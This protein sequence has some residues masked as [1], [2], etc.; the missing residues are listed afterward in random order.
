MS[1]KEKICSLAKSGI[2]SKDMLGVLL[3][4]LVG[5]EKFIEI[6]GEIEKY[7]Y[8]EEKEYILTGLQISH[9]LDLAYF[10][11]IEKMHAESGKFDLAQRPVE[12][13]LIRA[14]GNEIYTIITDIEKVRE[15]RVANE[16]FK[17]WG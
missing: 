14:A 16:V 4:E 15:D 9:L 5:Q 3:C 13:M 12:A 8:D 6:M 7:S 11:C 1:T 17:K 2:K 10:K